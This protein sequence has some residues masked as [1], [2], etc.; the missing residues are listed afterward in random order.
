MTLCFVLTLEEL[1]KFHDSKLKK[2]KSEVL[3]SSISFESVV[4]DTQSIL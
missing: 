2:K 1:L 4:T 3:K